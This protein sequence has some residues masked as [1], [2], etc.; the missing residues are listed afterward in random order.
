MDLLGNNK[1]D[2]WLN[3]F[4]RGVLFLGALILLGR[5][6][7]LQ[8]IKGK[9]FRSLSDDNRIREITLPA[10][11]GKILARGGEVL[12]TNR[13]VDKKIVYSPESGYKKVDN[14][15]STPSEGLISLWVRDYPLKDAFSHVSGY[16]GM[17]NQ[18]E[19]SKV[20]AQCIQKGA[21]DAELLVGRGGLE[22]KYNCSLSGTFGKELIEVDTM[23]KK[24]RILG[25]EDPVPGEDLKTNINFG[26]QKFVATLLDGVKGAIVV[27]D[28]KGQILA[29]YSSPAFDPNAFV[30]VQNAD[31]VKEYL[32]DPAMPLFDRAI[33][34]LYHPGSVFKQVTAVAALESGVIDASYRYNDTGQLILK[35]LY[36][37]YT[38][39][40]WYF[41]QYGRSEGEI[42]VT[43]AIAR[44]T[45]TFFYEM[46]DLLGIE[47]LASW[48]KKYG[49]NSKSGIDIPGE[50]SGLVPDPEWKLR[51][52]GEQ[53]F[54]GNTYHMAIGQ[55]DLALTPVLVNQITQVTASGGKLCEQKVVGSSSCKDLGISKNSFELVKQ[56]MKEACSQGGTGYTFFDSN[57]SVGC[58]T[59]TAE[60]FEND[61]THAW[62]TFFAPTDD[63]QIVATVFVEK[64]GEGSK[65]AGPVARKIFDFWF[66]KKIESTY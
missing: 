46:G 1:N 12:V 3:W 56:G 41:T 66:G 62:F 34:G 30:S 50:I 31:K 18:D 8:V 45:D 43:R 26:L 44:S 28:I 58:K 11:R 54:L 5:L 37:T 24:I 61:K 60:T 42:D 40:N 19:V 53:W 15:D 38:Y 20:D 65:V 13:K 55:G 25:K 63:P 35:T 33:S 27:S 29:L 2:S 49:L 39:N 23:E 64:G 21:R 36:G 4:L 16:V 47:K 17:V 59:G 10:P 48:A 52:K 32:T 51:I 14:A 7:E 57:P 22:E 6:F 9:Y